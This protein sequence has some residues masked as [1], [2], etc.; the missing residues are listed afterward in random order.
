MS[1]QNQNAAV[2]Q[3]YAD[4]AAPQQYAAQG[5]QYAPVQQFAP[6][7]Q[8]QYAPQQYAP[9]P[10]QFA[11]Y[12]QPVDPKLQGVYPPGSFQSPVYG[13]AVQVT[14]AEHKTSIQAGFWPGCIGGFCCGPLGL[15][16]LFFFQPPL[17][18]PGGDM[19]PAIDAKGKQA[20]VFYGAAAGI[21]TQT[22]LWII[23]VIVALTSVY[24]YTYAGYTYT[25]G[26]VGT[27]YIYYIVLAVFWLLVSGG[28]YYFGK[29]R[30]DELKKEFNII[31]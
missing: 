7:P 11:G 18:A 24:T 25:V 19:R 26:Y 15:L 31:A 2:P 23:L 30:S 17:V 9:P 5:Q 4:P 12:A 27:V 8:Q 20:G 1:E 10:Q 14:L 6:P 3:P 21:G 22:L 28:A 16:A 13:Q 29:K